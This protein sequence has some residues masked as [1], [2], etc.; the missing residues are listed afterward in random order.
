MQLPAWI[1]F[2]VAAMV[3]IFG[4]YRLRL[5]VMP[6]DQYQ[7]LSR[8]GGFYRVAQRS[9]LVVGALF[10]FMCLFLITGALG[11]NPILN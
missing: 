2:L 7:A 4:V 1:T 10:V 3:G 6:R 9:H 8:R 5:G 11:V